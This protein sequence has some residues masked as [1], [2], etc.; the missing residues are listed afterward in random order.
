M[1]VESVR[2]GDEQAELSV[3]YPGKGICVIQVRCELDMLTAPSLA[4][5]LTQELAAGHRALVVDLAGCDFMGSSGLAT[6]VAARDQ[7]RESGTTLALAGMSQIV[8]R[9]LEAT[10]L[11]SL[12][13]TY[14]AVEQAVSALGDSASTGDGQ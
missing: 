9:A 5:L 11:K 2:N 1:A 14:P 8:D 4:Q 12:F 7:A 3:A 6:L 10:A 13:D